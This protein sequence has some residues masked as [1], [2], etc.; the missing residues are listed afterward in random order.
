MRRREGGGERVLFKNSRGNVPGQMYAD[1]KSAYAS[2][3]I[4]SFLPG[5]SPV[6]R[7]PTS[8]VMRREFWQTFQCRFPTPCLPLSSESVGFKR[9]V[10]QTGGRIIFDY[11]ILCRAL[12]AVRYIELGVG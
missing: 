9:D 4:P 8:L 6:S 3:G 2:R 5:F 11:I 7:A 1:F 12:G 10:A